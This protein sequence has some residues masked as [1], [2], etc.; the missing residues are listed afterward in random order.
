M[1]YIEYLIIEKRGKRRDY[2]I[3]DAIILS[4]FYGHLVSKT[5]LNFAN[6]NLC[7]QQLSLQRLLG[8]A[9]IAH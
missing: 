6:V 2:Y 1:L 4:S 8:T 9:T 7:D 5:T 3:T